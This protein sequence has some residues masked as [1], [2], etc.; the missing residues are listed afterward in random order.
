[1]GRTVSLEFL[2]PFD[3]PSLEFCRI[4]HDGGF[5]RA[6]HARDPVIE[7]GE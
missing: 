3:G 6:F 5:A 2:D 4:A 7:R 1:M